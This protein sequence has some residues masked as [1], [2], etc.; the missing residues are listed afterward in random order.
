[1]AEWEG[2]NM[3]FVRMASIAH[4][5]MAHAQL[6]F[7]VNIISWVENDAYTA[8]DYSLAKRMI[9]LYEGEYTKPCD[10]PTLHTQHLVCF[11]TAK[12][13]GVMRKSYV[14]EA[15]ITFFEKNPSPR[16]K[17]LFNAQQALLQSVYELNL[18]ETVV[19]RQ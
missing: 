14:H 3:D 4:A 7:F 16:I 17:F 18:K 10:Y 1:M 5:S 13:I 15:S 12:V 11:G 19:L 6:N 9:P 8:V 2:D